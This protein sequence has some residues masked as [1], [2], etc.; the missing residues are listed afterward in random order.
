MFERLKR[1]ILPDVRFKSEFVSFMYLF[2]C[3]QG[4]LLFSSLFINLFLLNGSDMS[5]ICIYNGVVWA[6]QPFA[7]FL[8]GYLGK[9]TNMPLQIR[10]SMISLSLVYLILIL[11]GKSAAD[12]AVLLGVFTGVA[13]GFYYLPHSYLINELND[14]TTVDAGLNSLSLIGSIEGILIPLISGAI[15]TAMP[16][17]NGYL[18]VFCCSLI[19]ML[20]AFFISFRLPKNRNQTSYKIAPVIRR[21]FGVKSW[22]LMLGID[23]LR[24]FREG[25]LAFIISILMFLC[26]PNELFVSLNS[27][28]CSI[29]TIIVLSIILKRLNANNRLNYYMIYSFG[30]FVASCVLFFNQ[31]FLVLFLFSLVNAVGGNITANTSTAM[32]F[33]VLNQW[34]FITEYRS[35]TFALRETIICYSRVV[36]MAILFFIEQKGVKNIT[37]IALY[38]AGIC[39]LQFLM[40]FLLKLLQKE[41]R[42]V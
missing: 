39:F 32:E 3:F 29:A 34:E 8:S 7:Y 19:L 11:L 26:V 2:S 35:E 14:R 20:S 27:T 40:T 17:I 38:I 6:V 12:Y 16:G 4:A 41:T 22:R 10:I 5:H 23:F 30:I 15:V 18:T 9:K 31:G 28:V 25:G 33:D 1:M 21:Y 13:N 37:I 24:A 42:E 36:M